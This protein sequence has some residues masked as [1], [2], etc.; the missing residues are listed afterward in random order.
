MRRGSSS[1]CRAT[2]ACPGRSVS[3]S[4]SLPLCLSHRL[5]HCVSGG[6]TATGT[7][8]PLQPG[9]PHSHFG[10]YTRV[11]DPFFDM[12]DHRINQLG[13][14]LLKLHALQAMRVEP[15]IDEENP[16][17]APLP[18]TLPVVSVPRTS[19]PAEVLHRAAQQQN[20]AELTRALAR[21]RCNVNAVEVCAAPRATRVG[22]AH[23]CASIGIHTHPHLSHRRVAARHCTWR[24]RT[25][26]SRARRRCCG[27]ERGP[28][29][30][31]RFGGSPAP[32]M[33]EGGLSHV[34]EG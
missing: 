34:A 16:T 19:E 25:A 1:R 17:P 3:P 7:V 9:A 28:T 15:E 10:T 13:S 11:H 27:R 32:D 20:L 12:L 26:G 31:T 4:P 33:H 5:S 8:Y 14:F 6:H 18:A 2:A 24:R 30:P 23:S 22:G 21:P 29:S